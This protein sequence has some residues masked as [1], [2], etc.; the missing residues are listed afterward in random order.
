MLRVAS[1]DLGPRAAGRWGLAAA[2]LLVLLCLASAPGC[3]DTGGPH[4]ASQ[5]G[6]PDAK[7]RDLC[8][9]DATDPGPAPD[10]GRGDARGDPS[11]DTSEL[12]AIEDASDAEATED[13]PDPAPFPS[14]LGARIPLDGQMLYPLRLDGD[15]GP[16][17]MVV[18]TGAI[19]T[20]VE[21]SLLAEVHNGVGSITMDFGRGILLEDYEVLAGDLSRA[22]EHIGVPLSGL[23]GQDLFLRYYFGLDYREALVYMAE[24]TPLA[25]PPGF[26]LEERLILP[27]D[28]VQGLP[29][30]ELT[31]E[32]RVT[33]LIADT[34]SG[35]TLLVRS[36]VPPELLENCL[37]GYVWHTSFGSDPGCILRLPCLE[38]AGFQVHDSWAVV[39][40]DDFHLRPV[41]DLIGVDAQGFVGYPVYR[42]FFVGVRGH[43]N[44]YELYPY[45]SM[46]HIS[47]QEWDRVGIELRR[48]GERV[49]IDMLFEP[50]DA[51]DCGLL[52]EDELLALDGAPLAPLELDELRL[53]LRG[54]PG[55]A[56]DLSILRGDERMEVSV[57]V[58]RLLRP[59]R[60]P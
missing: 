59:A 37:G 1:P 19:R 21:E 32:G 42:R 41:F 27:Y 28:L 14:P 18:D 5:D 11:P 15:P 4:P 56:R 57:Q 10:T 22:V 48:E 47:V 51:F 26:E 29:I 45:D 34:G 39:V 43:E 31:I 24:S 17:W 16:Y 6:H 2:A 50:S 20:V 58:D 49:F 44:L 52:P 38:I 25:P 53:R 30:V 9:A 60:L 46:E 36:A 40:P 12:G 55:E 54:S 3:R 7:A 13:V 33:R 35:V 8:P 23:L